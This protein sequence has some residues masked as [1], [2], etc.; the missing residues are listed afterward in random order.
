MFTAEVGRLPVPDGL[1]TPW[2]RSCG[3]ATEPG[4]RKV[5]ETRIAK[6]WIGKPSACAARRATIYAS[7]VWLTKEEE[8]GFYLA[9]QMKGSGP[10]AISHTRARRFT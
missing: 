3:P 7:A 4:W 6:P 2:N 10:C 1:V 5:R 9:S 8:E